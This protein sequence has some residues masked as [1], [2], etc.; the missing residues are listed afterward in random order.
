MAT[1]KNTTSAAP[2]NTINTVGVAGEV[3]PDFDKWSDLQ[4]GFSPY[5]HP[6]EGEF[7]YGSLIAIDARNPKFIRFQFKAGKTTECRRGP[8][9]EDEKAGAVGEQVTVKP[10]ETFSVSV[11]YSLVEEFKYHNFFRVKTGK[12]VPIRVDAL[13]KTKTANAEGRMVWNFR[14]RAEDSMK[15]ELE[16]HRSEYRALMA[17]EDA[18]RPQLPAS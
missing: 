8:A 5:W 17:A 1:S 15:A 16:V 13:K 6:R 3:L 4:I 18:E 10:G 2:V 9:N 7:I 11:Y 12:E 14:V